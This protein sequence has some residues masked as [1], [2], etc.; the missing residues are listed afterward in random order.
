[1]TRTYFIT[2]G[3]GNLAC[4]LSFVLPRS[5]GRIVLYDI[6]ERPVANVDPRCCYV[7]GDLTRPEELLQQFRQH[8]PDVVLHLASLLSA[9]CEQDRPLAWRVNMDGCFAMFEAAVAAGVRRVF[10]PSSVA[11]YGSPLPDPL[12]EEFPQWPTGLYGVTKVAAERLGLYYHHRHGLDFRC[13]RLPVVLSPYAP[14]GA[15]S[16]YGSRA[17]I[18]SVR[19]G[20]F[21]F[22]V[23]PTTRAS[24]LYVRDALAALVGLVEAPEAALRRRVYNIFALAPSAQE[25]ADVIAARLPGVDLSF[26]PDPATVALIESWPARIMDDSARR[27]WNWNPVDDLNRMADDFIAELKQCP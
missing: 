17:F 8:Q 4:Q 11:S 23:R 6:A 26:D 13:V 20:R 1:M 16:A 2:G 7:R 14:A 24:V 25:I 3:A 22:R 18:E 27:D 21:V 12:P 9:G 10:F 5:V 19:A 15:A